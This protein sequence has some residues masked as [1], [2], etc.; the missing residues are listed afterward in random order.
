[1][2]AS[3]RGGL[4]LC[5]N[6]SILCL[7]DRGEWHTRRRGL[8]VHV[9]THPSAS[10]TLAPPPPPA[11]PHT[12]SLFLPLQCVIDKKKVI[13]PSAWLLTLVCL[14][15]H[16]SPSLSPNTPHTPP[17]SL[18]MFLTGTV[19]QSPSGLL[20]TSHSIC[21]SSDF[22][23]HCLPRSVNL[24]HQLKEVKHATLLQT[25]QCKSIYR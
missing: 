11:P 21:N 3:C 20:F 24:C 6:F 19:S 1:M 16:F 17:H 10:P 8:V 14:L 5:S 2:P 13:S 25:G 18:F 15:L 23:L 7:R 12:A 9:S 4:R 22:P